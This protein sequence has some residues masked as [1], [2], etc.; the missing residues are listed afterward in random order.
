MRMHSYLDIKLDYFVITSALLA[1][2]FF[3]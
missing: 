1:V 3:K 2:R